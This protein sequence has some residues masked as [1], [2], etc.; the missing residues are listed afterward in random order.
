MSAFHPK[1]TLGANVRKRPI[2]DTGNI[3]DARGMVSF[4]D[5]SIPWRWVPPSFTA[6]LF[7]RAELEKALLCFRNQ[8][9]N[10]RRASANDWPRG[11][12]IGSDFRFARRIGAGFTVE[13]GSEKLFL[14]P[15]G[16]DEPEWGLAVYD[17]Q[18]CLWRHL[19]DIEPT[20]EKWN[21][22]DVVEH[23]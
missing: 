2:A 4:H 5:P 14:V 19:G 20:P 23:S 10:W 18:R 1:R 15:R 6:G 17:I 16:W 11:W 21:F 9:L 12:F 7:R 3:R 22:P 8:A 13:I